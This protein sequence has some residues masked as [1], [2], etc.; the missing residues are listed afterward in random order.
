MLPDG[1]TGLGAPGFPAASAGVGATL[2]PTA[3]VRGQRVALPGSGLSRD[4]KRNK[5]GQSSNEPI[6]TTVIADKWKGVA[7]EEYQ[8]PGDLL[9]VRRKTD[10]NGES[11]PMVSLPQ[12]QE[13]LRLCYQSIQTYRSNSLAKRSPFL[14]YEGTEASAPDEVM[15]LFEESLEKGESVFTAD[16]RIDEK[17]TNDSKYSL[18]WACSPKHIVEC[19]K[20]LG[21]YASDGG[22]WRKPHLT[23]NIQV[24]G[25]STYQET[26]N[27]WGNVVEGHNLFL[28]LTRRLD[29]E[30]STP[31]RPVYAEFYFKP[32]Y[33]HTEYPPK[34]ETVYYDDA[35][36]VRYGRVINVGTVLKVPTEFTT[37]ELSLVKAGIN[38]NSQQ[39]FAVKITT[40][41]INATARRICRE[42]YEN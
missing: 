30:R 41:A 21:L 15:R 27:I 42:L 19:Y 11:Y 14:V 35:G 38:T 31:G 37:K 13:I 26:W 9:F 24:G 4:G 10:G 36:F 16:P 3:G 32:W 28:I 40:V 33:G 2:R 23:Y 1:L 6:V 39:A 25:P 7:Y 18:L 22:R 34:Q 29:A 20:W 17:I 5:S 8:E 12:L